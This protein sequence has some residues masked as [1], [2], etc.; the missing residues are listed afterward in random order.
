MCAT[1]T[2]H[3]MASVQI[4][5]FGKT[6]IKLELKP[7]HETILAFPDQVI[8]MQI[9][10]AK[11]RS[12]LD[13][14]W[15]PEGNIYLT[16]EGN[17]GKS[18]A[19]F[20]LA[21]GKVIVVYL[22]AR[23]SGVDTGEIHIKLAQKSQSTALTPNAPPKDPML[24]NMPAFLQQQYGLTEE[25]RP[26]ITYKTMTQFALRHFS[27]PKR[28]INND[29]GATQIKMPQRINGRQLL[30]VWSDR[31]KLRGLAQWRIDDYFVSA[32]HADNKSGLKVQFDPRALRGQWEFVAALHPVL[33]PNG[34]RTDQ[35]IWVFIS[36]MPFKQ[37]LA[38]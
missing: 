20:T 34:S 11:T 5:T 38:R 9:K 22:Y 24:A 7:G 36:K 8:D 25:T 27:G 30:R 1:L 17:F 31:L 33:F 2:F 32:V 12:L 29:I 16:P 4:K 26:T 37:A 23:P 19:L 18:R 15:A 21:D 10:D 35:T 6:P 13:V 28:L 3:V 14:L